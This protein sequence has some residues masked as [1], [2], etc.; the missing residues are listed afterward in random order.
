MCVISDIFLFIFL[1]QPPEKDGKG[2]CHS[3][4][5]GLCAH[6]LGL[7]AHEHHPQF[8]HFFVVVTHTWRRMVKK[9]AI[10]E[11]MVGMRMSITGSMGGG[12][13]CVCL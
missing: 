7:C 2:E 10:P 1:L 3:R 9:S 4:Q 12:A 8:L 11:S 5:H 6:E 13:A